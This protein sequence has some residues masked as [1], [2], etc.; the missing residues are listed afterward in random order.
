MT[1]I[2]ERKKTVEYKCTWF[3]SVSQRLFLLHYVGI[4]VSCFVYQHVVHCKVINEIWKVLLLMNWWLYIC[5]HQPSQIE[6][7]CKFSMCVMFK[8]NEIVSRLLWCHH[9]RQDGWRE[10]NKK[11]REFWCKFW[12]QDHSVYLI[13]PKYMFKIKENNF[14]FC[15]STLSP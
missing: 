2:F 4:Y 15:L 11:K 6:I 10:G 13:L 3:I 7:K 12:T 9:K 1:C 14:L 5:A 8:V